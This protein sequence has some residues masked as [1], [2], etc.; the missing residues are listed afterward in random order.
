MI[1]NQSLTQEI[2]NIQIHHQ[3]L[4][5]VLILNIHLTLRTN[6]ND[7]KSWKYNVSNINPPFPSSSLNRLKITFQT[8]FYPKINYFTC[9][10]PP[11]K[12]FHKAMIQAD[13]VH[14]QSHRF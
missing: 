14:D 9:N 11:R 5:K 7:I 13:T 6:Y 1:I 3:D 2:F 4:P 12:I 8:F 10:D